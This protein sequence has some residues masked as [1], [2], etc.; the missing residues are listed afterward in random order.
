MSTVLYEQVGRNVMPPSD[1]LR[2]DAFLSVTLRGAEDAVEGPK[3][4]AEKRKPDFR[5]R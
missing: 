2:L 5:A 4:F 3:A 1:E